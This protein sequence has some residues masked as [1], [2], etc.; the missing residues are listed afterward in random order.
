MK[1]RD[2]ELLNELLANQDEIE[3]LQREIVRIP[4]IGQANPECLVD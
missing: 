2:E 1:T 3:K 4:D